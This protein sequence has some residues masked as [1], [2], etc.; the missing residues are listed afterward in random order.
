MSSG[1]STRCNVVP[2]EPSCLPR[3]RPDF[4]REERFFAGLLSFGPS[5]D[6]GLPEVEEFFLAAVSNAS[7]RS[8]LGDQRVLRRDLS[9]L[10]CQQRS[11][12]SIPIGQHRNDL[13]ARHLR[14]GLHDP[15]PSGSPNPP[16]PCL[17]SYGSTMPTTSRWRSR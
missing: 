11:M 12:S 14:P 15:D 10:R 1:S 8:Q 6:G 5:E 2:D 17:N 3:L 9:I 16:S 4:A 13:I 7:I